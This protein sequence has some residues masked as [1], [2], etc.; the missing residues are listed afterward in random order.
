MRQVEQGHKVTVL[1]CRRKRFKPHQEIVGSH[2]LVMRLNNVWLPWDSLGM[3]NPFLPALST[4]IRQLDFDLIHAHS[5]LF[6]MTATAVKIAKAMKKPV[7]TTV[8]GVLAERNSF[9]NLAQYSYLYTFGSRVFKNSTR[10]ICLTNSDAAEIV[11]FGANPKKIRV[12][13]N[14]VDTSLFKPGEEN[15][16]K[17][18]WVGRFVPEKG[19]QY[20]VK[21]AKIVLSEHDDV[22]FVLVGEGP[23]RLYIMKLATKNGLK[24]KISFAGKMSQREVA[25][26]MQSASVFVL[27]SLREGFPKTLLEAMACGKPVIA[28]NIPGVNNVIGN[29]RGGILVPPKEPKALAETIVELLDDKSLRLKLGSRA[30]QLVLERY[31]WTTVSDQIESVYFE[32]MKDMKY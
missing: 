29:T 21:A 14:A 24:E 30:R 19:I 13:P 18:V 17:L 20:L 6:W 27:P 12:V 9:V 4:T 23:L 32:A 22:K 1:T 15:G 16:N 5:H 26:V 3:T 31:N 28:S 10:T 2:Y 11:R 8:H 7:V 25:Q